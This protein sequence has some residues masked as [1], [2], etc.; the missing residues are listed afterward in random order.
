MLGTVSFCGGLTQA[1]YKS[2]VRHGRA[3]CTLWTVDCGGRRARRPGPRADT[4][5]AQRRPPGAGGRTGRDAEGRRRGGGSSGRLTHTQHARE[6]TA[7]P[8]SRF[9]SEGPGRPPRGLLQHPRSVGSK[10]GFFQAEIGP[11]DGQSL[12]G[13]PGRIQTEPGR[14]EAAQSWR[15]P[16]HLRRWGGRSPSGHRPEPRTPLRF[17]VLFL[18]VLRESAQPGPALPRPPACPPLPTSHEGVTGDTALHP[19]PRPRGRSEQ[20][21]APGP[22]AV[23]AKFCTQREK[24]YFLSKAFASLLKRSPFPH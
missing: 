8:S 20:P 9:S 4:G 1:G 21:G 24:G 7:R 10:G 14:Q 5:G 17:H 18:S 3:T 23:T 2:G 15:G 16:E 12:S 6:L 11:V 13:L 22:Q 19:A